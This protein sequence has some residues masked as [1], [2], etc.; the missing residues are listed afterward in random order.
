MTLSELLDAADARFIQ[1]ERALTARYLRGDT[2]NDDEWTES[3]ESEAA[4]DA[5]WQLEDRAIASGDGNTIAKVH[6]RRTRDYL[7]DAA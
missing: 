6:R 4:S 3:M 7:D 1:A 5:L 2:T